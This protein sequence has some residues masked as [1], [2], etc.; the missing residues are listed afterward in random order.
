M[1]ECEK[2]AVELTDDMQLGDLSPR[3]NDRR[4]SVK[5]VPTV[6][7]R[8]ASRGQHDGPLRPYS[9]LSFK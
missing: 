4:L 9:G 3:A 5:V 6:A 1:G 2:G 7:N 8:G